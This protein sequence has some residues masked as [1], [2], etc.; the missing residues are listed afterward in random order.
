MSIDF[1]YRRPAETIAAALADLQQAWAS[2]D[3]DSRAA[4]NATLAAGR[5]QLYA[6][7]SDIGRGQAVMALLAALEATS[8]LPA[9][10]AATL[11]ASHQP[12]TRSVPML[13]ESNAR[14][15]VQTIDA[16]GNPVI[17][18]VVGPAPPAG[19]EVFPEAVKTARAVIGRLNRQWATLSLAAQDRGRQHLIT[20]GNALFDAANDYQRIEATQEFLRRIKSDPDLYAVTEAAFTRR[21]APVFGPG[22]LLAFSATDAAQLRDLIQDNPS[23]AIAKEPITT[24]LDEPLFTPAIIPPQVVTTTIIMGNGDALPAAVDY[25]SDVHCPGEVSIFDQNIPLRV[26][27]TLQKSADTVLD[28]TVAVTF[29]TPEPQMLQVICYATGFIVD[30]Q[31]SQATRTILVYPGRDSQW[32]V[33]LLNPLPEAGAG[34]RRITLDFYHDERP[35]GTGSFEIEVRDRPPVKPERPLLPAALVGGAG[36]TRGEGELFSNIVFALPAAVKTDFVLRIA[37]DASATLLSYTLHSPT[38]KL[39]LVHEP[40]G[41]I[42]L[43][44]DARTYLENT[45]LGL[46]Q[47][48]RGSKKNLTAAEAEDNRQHLRE[49]GWGLYEDLFPPQLRQR[50]RQISQLQ[51]PA[52]SL[53]LLIVSDEPW[54]PWEMVLPHEDDLPNEDFLCATFKLARW[55]DGASMPERVALRRV[56]V[57]I[58]KSD[59]KSVRKEQSYFR[60]T[61]PTAYPALTVDPA[62]LGKLNEVKAAL[63]SGQAQLFHFACHG[64]FDATR[65][66]DSA[67]VLTGGDLTPSQIVGPLRTGI[68]TSQPVVFLNACHSAEA[69]FSLTG[70]GG[71]AARFVRAGATAFIGSLW[72][73]NDDL[74]ASFAVEF[75][76]HW[77][78]GKPFAEAGS[79]A[80]AAIR[81]ADDTNPTWLAY[82]LYGDPNGVVG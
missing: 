58:P 52:G 54:I 38:G 23:L 37:L 50:Y 24:A 69:S 82:T 32:A 65:P 73:V 64:D 12:R 81:A 78:A 75:Y 30:D 49:I 76:T 9:A 41:S 44:M 21:A 11:G 72:E 63:Q 6:A 34:A 16:L 68:H 14:Q 2:L 57:V 66:D 79:L 56:E 60:D 48:A 4:L 80:R 15:I 26:R 43:Q 25:H 18:P 62:W 1:E 67:L 35:V 28:T 70:I 5:S 22:G 47:M 45:L 31:T 20:Y 29:D 61:V 46:S 33:F 42:K 10:A 39:G 77:L 27:L 36:D 59:L 74:A 8:G 13:S 19:Q 40:V 3:P 71:W 55:L 51:Q 53:S 17:A 7:S